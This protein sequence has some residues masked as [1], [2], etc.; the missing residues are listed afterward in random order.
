MRCTPA[1]AQAAKLVGD[2]RAIPHGHSSPGAQRVGRCA[3]TSGPRG[4]LGGVAPEDAAGHQRAAHRLRRAPGGP[5]QIVQLAV[6]VGVVGRRQKDTVPLRGVA[7]DQRQRP[8]RPVA[9][10]EDGRAAGACRARQQD[11]IAQAVVVAVE[12]D[13]CVAVQQPRHN[14][15]PL[16]EAGKARPHVEQLPAVVGV[17][18][19]LPARAEAQRQPPAGQVIDGRG[20]ARRQCRV[21]EGDGRDERAE[22]E[23]L[24]MAGQPGQRDPQ[25]Q[26]LLVGRVGV[27]VVVRAVEADEAQLFRCVGQPLPARPGQAVLAFDHESDFHGR[28]PVSSVAVDC[29]RNTKGQQAH[30]TDLLTH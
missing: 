16:F 7:R 4:Y 26:R 19:C 27:G 22:F 20:H 15:Q 1:A 17:F 11:G 24:G 25:L 18:A 6:A 21:A 12:R 10:D 23:A 28:Y 30:L 3:A 29:I 2:R 9:T 14:L 5:Q 8:S 13:R